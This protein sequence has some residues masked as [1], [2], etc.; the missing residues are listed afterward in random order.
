MSVSASVQ[1][2]AFVA[3]RYKISLFFLFKED[4]EV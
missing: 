3:C 4:L 2:P 1:D